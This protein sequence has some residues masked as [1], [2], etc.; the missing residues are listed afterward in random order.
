MSGKK[1]VNTNHF[2]KD[3]AINVNNNEGIAPG[4]GRSSVS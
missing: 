4:E 2:K 1:K 3:L